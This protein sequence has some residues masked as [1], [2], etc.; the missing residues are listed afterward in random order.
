M[1]QHTMIVSFD[2]PLPDAEL[3]QYLADIERVML[4]SGAVQSV[5]T[6]RH[7]PVP[8]E[9]AIPALIATAI[10]QLSVADMDALAKAFGAPG[11]HEVIGR[12]QSRH[13]Y[14]VAWANHEALA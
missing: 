5:A 11:V 14:K 1:I 4:D 10:V 6:R 9:D 3:D 8:G 2:Q 12:W 7:L 13:P